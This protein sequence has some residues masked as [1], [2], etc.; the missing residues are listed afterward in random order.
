[1]RA[2]AH[3]DS[4]CRRL[5]LLRGFLGLSGLLD[6]LGNRRGL[7]R[8]R[9]ASGRL[10]GLFRGRA[11]CSLLAHRCL[12]RRRLLRRSWGS[13][14]RGIISGN[15]RSRDPVRLDGRRSRSWLW[16]IEIDH[17]HHRHFRP[18]RAGSRTRP[19]PQSS[20]ARSDR[21]RTVARLAAGIRGSNRSAPLHRDVS[22]VRRKLELAV[23]DHP[24]VGDLGVVRLPEETPEALRIQK[25]IF[26]AM[27]CSH[28][29]A[30]RF[31]RGRCGQ[32]AERTAEQVERFGQ[33]QA[34]DRLR[35]RGGC[36]RCTGW[37]V[38]PRAA[39]PST[40]A[41]T[42]GAFFALCRR[43]ARWLGL[44]RGAGGRGGCWG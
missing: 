28:P 39:T 27:E 30:H 22:L 42:T 15:D 10:R 32:F 31:V 26:L 21:R 17:A 14:R 13:V 33:G 23:G 6:R 1:M 40:P 37:L 3:R 24:H 18:F 35:C 11:R 36:R 19:V 20:G 9:L 4:A 16:R 44:R 29:G 2:R 5:R 34:G 43:F 38:S 7:G 41:T 8:L 25:R 12:L